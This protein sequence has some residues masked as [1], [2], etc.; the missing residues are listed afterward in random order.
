M[1]HIKAPIDRHVR[2]C[3]N[4]GICKTAVNIGCDLHVW[5]MCAATL[6]SGHATEYSVLISFQGLWCR[7][8]WSSCDKSDVENKSLVHWKWE[9]TS[10]FVCRLVFD[11]RKLCLAHF[12]SLWEQTVLQIIMNVCL[13]PF[14]LSGW[15]L[16][17]KCCN[18]CA[19]EDHNTL[20]CFNSLP[21]VIQILQPC[22]YF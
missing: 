15:K 9:V 11:I 7:M 18:C 22:R 13:L 2:W 16:F 4:I 3:K 10:L 17:V 6:S 19:T 12:S 20:L 14:V 21:S 1:W 5:E 8:I